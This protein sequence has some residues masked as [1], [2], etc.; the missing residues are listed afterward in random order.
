MRRPSALLFLTLLA[1]PATAQD[2]QRPEG[3]NVRLDRPNMTEADIEQFV[4]MPPGWHITT[5]HAAGIFYDPKMTA[6]GEYT[7]SV[8]IHLFDPGERHREAYG[9]FFGGSD[10]QGEGQRYSYFLLRD[11]G[12]FIVKQRVGA[13]APT[14]VGWTA[15]DAI[16]KFAGQGSV[17]NV[18]EV[19]VGA[20]S[21]RFFV[22]GQHA[23][24]VAKSRLSTDGVYGL[25]LNH[26]LNVHVEP[27]EVKQGR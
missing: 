10:L 4:A 25:R 11:T 2:L 6:S 15:N 27:F 20:D 13:E 22:N 26:A 19:R 14:V 23:T 1:A 12:E 9:V 21:V 5:G 7:M 17:P 8:K 24:S 3:W 18:L 16:K